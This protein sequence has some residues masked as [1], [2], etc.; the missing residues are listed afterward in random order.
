MTIKGFLD[1]LRAA[2]RTGLIGLLILRREDSRTRNDFL[3]DFGSQGELGRVL[4]G[5]GDWIESAD[6]GKA[7]GKKENSRSL[8][9]ARDEG[10]NR[11]APVI[12]RGCNLGTECRPRSTFKD[13]SASAFSSTFTFRHVNLAN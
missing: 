6:C 10:T 11:T 8:D 9:F 12:S 7:K 13:N 1:W 5:S 3:G 2:V 4:V